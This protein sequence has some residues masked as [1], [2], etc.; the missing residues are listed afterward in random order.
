MNQSAESDN[1][2]FSTRALRD[3]EFH[4]PEGQ[5]RFEERMGLST[6][7]ETSDRGHHNPRH[8]DEERIEEESNETGRSS[9]PGTIGEQHEYMSENIESNAIHKIKNH[10][11]YGNQSSIGRKE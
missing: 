10:K 2:Q 6:H 3:M 8:R 7:V 9:P 5:M 4:A 1:D 11:G